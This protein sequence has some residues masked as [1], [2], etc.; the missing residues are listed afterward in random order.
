MPP[1][2]DYLP[3][4][5]SLTD[6]IHGGKNMCSSIPRACH[7]P[8]VVRSNV[9]KRPLGPIGTTNAP[10]DFRKE[11]STYNGRIGETHDSGR[12]TSNTK[13]NPNGDSNELYQSNPWKVIDTPCRTNLISSYLGNSITNSYFLSS[14]FS[15]AVVRRQLIRIYYFPYQLL[16]SATLF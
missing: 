8:P 3:L 9:L 5:C 7:D 11:R 16:R 1:E 4:C 10:R 6:T 14:S 15:S 2:V 12:N 13:T